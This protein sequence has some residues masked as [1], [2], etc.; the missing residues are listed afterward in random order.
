[1][2][3][4]Y[5]NIGVVGSREFTNYTLLKSTLDFLLKHESRTVQIVSGGAKG[6]DSLAA[7]FAKER[8]FSLIVFRPKWLDINVLGARIKFDKYGRA[9]NANAGFDRNALIVRNSDV[10]V[11]FTYASKGGTWDTIQ[12]AKEEGI[13]VII[14]EEN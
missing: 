1:M 13:P 11:A 12:R 9:Y 10:L 3:S 7:S 14:V 6:A 2:K 8:N 4:R 5:Y